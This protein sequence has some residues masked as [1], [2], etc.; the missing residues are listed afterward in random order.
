MSSPDCAIGCAAGTAVF[1]PHF[2][3]PKGRQ[4]NLFCGGCKIQNLDYPAQLEQ[5]KLRLEELFAPFWKNPITVRPS[6]QTRFYRNKMEFS[7]ARQV[8]KRNDD[9]SLE[10]ETAFGLKSAG[11]W[12]RVV[13]LSECGIF[14]LRSGELIAAVRKWAHKS[15][16][17]F[18]DLR[19][20]TGS[21]R[22]LLCREGKNTGEMM[23]ALYCAKSLGDDRA[24]ADT[25]LKIHLNATVLCGINDGLSDVAHTR[26]FRVLSGSGVMAEKISAGD[27]TISV[28]ISPRS[29]FQTNTNA[30]AMLYT[31]ARNMAREIRPPVIYD[32]YGGAGLFSIACS[33]FAQKCVCV[34]SVADAVFDGRANAGANGAG[35]VEF[36]TVSA[37]EF[38][39]A[40]R[41]E[42]KE[43][44]CIAD[45]PRSGFHPKALA[46]LIENKP[47]RLLY[48]SCNPE[49]LA[50]DLKALTQ[51]Y[52][53]DFVEGFDLFPHTPHVETAAALS[54]V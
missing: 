22:Q 5:K 43:A 11:R 40:P 20:R 38:L 26:E 8:A 35:N 23:F 18:Y 25:I 54:L 31:L 30:A 39:S 10:F 53:I 13:N 28:K 32:L 51:S 16:E 21:L 52:R 46:G 19:K 4:P 27:K 50:R 6:P 3:I 47:P 44:F 1:C 42:L 48:I 15:G 12:D 37:E 24:F 17:E 14:S 45:P 34:E 36:H 41:P 9:G 29:F 2:G 49:S 33:D 7:F